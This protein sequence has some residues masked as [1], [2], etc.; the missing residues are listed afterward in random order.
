MTGEFKAPLHRF[1]IGD[2]VVKNPQTWQK[3]EFDGW[4]RGLGVGGGG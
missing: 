4:G 3:N 1:K 2:R